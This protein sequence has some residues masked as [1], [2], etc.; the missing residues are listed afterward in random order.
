VT[1][2]HSMHGQQVLEPGGKRH[3]TAQA[4]R[5]EWHAPSPEYGIG[6]EVDSRHL[7]EESRVS[8]PR[9]LDVFTTR[10][11]EAPPINPHGVGAVG[12]NDR[13]I[14][15]RSLLRTEPQFPAE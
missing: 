13:A 11:V 12:G 10:P 14:D 2:Q 1:E 15:G 6:Q 3:P 9:D 7:D 5:R 4:E 8:D